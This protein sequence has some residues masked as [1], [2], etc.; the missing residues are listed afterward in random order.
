VPPCKPSGRN[1]TN[2]AVAP[3]TPRVLVIRLA[4]RRREMW[5]SIGSIDDDTDALLSS[6]GR[7]L[8]ISQI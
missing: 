1:T 7:V 5:L 6:I 2:L 3:D 8:T 4:V